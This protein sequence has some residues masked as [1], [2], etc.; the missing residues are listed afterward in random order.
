MEIS[1]IDDLLVGAKTATQPEAPEHRYQQDES[2]IQEAV[3]YDTDAPEYSDEQEPVESA[4]KAEEQSESEP[5]R[6][7]DEDEYG[8][9]TEDLSEKMQERLKRQAESMKRKHEAELAEL[10]AQ[11]AQLTPLQQQQV[12]NAA[13]DFEIDP[14][15]NASWEQ[16]LQGFI[17]NT[18]SNMTTKQQLAQQQAEEARVQRDFEDRFQN[19]M[20]KFPDFVETIEALPCTI[21]NPMT[22]ATRAMSDPAAFLYAAAKRAPEE[23]ERI[24]K[25]RDPYAQMTEMGKL[26]ERMRRNKPATKAPR[27]LGKAQEDASMPAP[28]KK[29]EDTIEDLIA[30]SQAKKLSLLNQRRGK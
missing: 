3:E 27:P 22:L 14:N 17:E 18:V 24:S 16:Q 12:Q 8:N 2:P 4:P 5:E 28:K 6:L 23:L 1:N 25:I 19:G 15:D 7:S 9:K 10:R 29:T 26:E 21:S 20:N 30:K 13:R 11:V